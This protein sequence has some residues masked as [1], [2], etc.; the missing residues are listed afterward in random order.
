MEQSN[1]MTY[2]GM[3]L[4]QSE[5]HGNG[6]ITEQYM[7]DYLMNRDEVGHAV[8]IDEISESFGRL[9]QAGFLEMYKG[10]REGCIYTRYVPQTRT[11]RRMRN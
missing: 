2:A 8:D 1:L 11:N 10:D 4:E 3:A 9:L 6:Q 7:Q 5:K